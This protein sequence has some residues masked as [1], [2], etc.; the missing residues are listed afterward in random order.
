MAR[1]LRRGFEEEG[2]AVDSA[3]GGDDAVWMATENAYDCIVLDVMIPDP[4]GFEVCRLLRAKSVW[5]PVVMLTARAAVGDRVR[6]LDAGADDYLTKPFSF[7][8]LLARV[9]AV[10]RRGTDERPAVLR[11]GD[12]TLDPAARIVHRAGS[13]IDL[14]PREFSVLEYLMRNAGRVL[15]RTAIR[16]HVW[17]WSYEGSSNVIDVYIRY[18]RSKVDKPHD[19]ELIRTV[20]G[21]GYTIGSP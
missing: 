18:L 20:R 10:M 14:T 9:R 4:D 2:Y 8:E 12:L 21:V 1:I 15:T 11:V 7:E 17:D 6:G 5:S 19:V 13:S 3:A 16:E